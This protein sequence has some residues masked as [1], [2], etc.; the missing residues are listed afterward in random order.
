MKYLIS[1]FRY[2]QKNS[3]GCFTLNIPYFQINSGELIF[4]YGSSGSGK[5]TFFN[6]ITGIK[7]SPLS[8][9][10]RE[11][12]PRIEYVMHESKILPWHTLDDNISVINSLNGK[13]NTNSLINICE[14]LGLKKDILNMK[15]W[16]LSQGMRQR[17]EIALSL[18]NYPDLIIFDEAMSGIDNKNKVIVSKL[19]YKYIK[20]HNVNL[21]ATA[22]QVSDILRL[23]ERVVFIKN[24]VFT[25]EIQIISYSVEERLKMSLEQLYTIPEA[26]KI[27][28]I[29]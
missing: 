12:F 11:V 5:S 9:A 8:C 24:G 3:S 10:I 17:F 1:D 26:K 27:M 2:D 28:N 19:V 21:L 4:I 6:L 29:E 16:Q 14:T 7:K 25:Q 18:S 15:S 13:I 22:H 23:A 20:E